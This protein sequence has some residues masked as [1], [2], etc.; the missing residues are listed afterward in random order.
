[1]RHATAAQNMTT[2]CATSSASA[3]SDDHLLAHENDNPA[4][5]VMTINGKSMSNAETQSP[6]PMRPV[7]VAPSVRPMNRGL[8]A[9]IPPTY[10]QHAIRR[11]ALSLVNRFRVI[12]TIDVALEGFPDRPFKTA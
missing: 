7:D 4:P 5:P 10:L 2:D 9:I 8:T 11:R 12:R 1:M 6:A 3:A